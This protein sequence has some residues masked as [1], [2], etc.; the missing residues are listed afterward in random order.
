[1][2]GGRASGPDDL[3]GLVLAGAAALLAVVW[4]GAQLDQLPVGGQGFSVVT[5]ER[6]QVPHSAPPRVL[7]G[8]SGMLGTDRSPTVVI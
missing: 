4:G 5:S 8:C 1:M 3:V 6:D 2:T 7:C